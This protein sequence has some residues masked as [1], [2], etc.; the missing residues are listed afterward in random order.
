MQFALGGFELA[1]LRPVL[2]RAFNVLRQY[3]V[4]EVPGAWAALRAG[5]AAGGLLVDGTC[6][7]LGRRCC[8]VLL[9][10]DGPVSL[11]LA[12]DPNIIE[13]PSDLAE[14]L[15]KV[16]IHH[17]VPG[18]PIH[19][20]LTAADRAWAT[21]SGQGVFGPR[22]RWREMVAELHR[23]GVPVAPQRRPLRDAVLTVPW[24]SSLPCDGC[25]AYAESHADCPGADQERHRPCANLTTVEEYT[26]RA[27]ADGA[28]LVVFPEA[29]MC[30]FGVPLQR[31][32]P[33]RWTVRGPT[34][35]A[36]PRRHAGITVVAGMFCPSGD[37][38][39]TNTLIAAG[40][41]STRTT[42]RSTSTTRS[43]SP[44]RET[45]APGPT[46]W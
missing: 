14:R 6:D 3:P 42:T 41:T 34:A 24:D 39:V 46:R 20:L 44:S 7:E 35:C 26:R 8:W 21:S 40:P 27:A 28:R 17:N 4:E 18:Q 38:R 43:G 33:N 31:R 32:W 15:P 36:G 25:S 13:R 9:D 10:R 5:L 2:V 11:T 23:A 30:R 22:V 45:V 12:C 1:G 29:T 19:T 37:G 16:L